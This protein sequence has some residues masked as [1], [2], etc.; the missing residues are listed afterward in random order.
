MKDNDTAEELVQ[1]LFYK[2][3]EKHESLQITTSLKAYLFNAVRNNSL[4]Y[5]EHL[6]IVDK[7]ARNYVPDEEYQEK[8]DDLIKVSELQQKIDSTLD[9]MPARVSRIFK[10]SRFDGLK[11]KE[12]ADK[13]NISI[14]TVEANMGIALK[15]FRKSLKDY[16]F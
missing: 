11:Y 2:F 13:L 8:T 16:R 9:K 10:L 15:T 6:K 14:K 12:I 4:K 7:Y 5:L 3:W 1:D